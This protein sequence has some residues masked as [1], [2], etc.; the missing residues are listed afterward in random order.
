MAVTTERSTGVP[1]VTVAPGAE[2]APA[3]PSNTTPEI[4][5]ANAAKVAE[6][7]ASAKGKIVIINAWATYCI[8]CIEEMP[9]LAQFYRERDTEK[10][11][12][13][14]FSADPEYTVE[15]TVK[16][17]VEEKAIP[18]PVYV[19]QDMP[20]DKLIAALGAES[21]GWDGELPATFVLDAEGTLK[22]HWLERVHLKDIAGAIADIR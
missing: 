12:F 17:F 18:F 19:L 3:Q 16:P 13:L 5:L 8:P 7:L 11:V 10:V 6:L 22:K 4:A 15:D 20:P 14:S 1:P 2:S 9:E 21:T